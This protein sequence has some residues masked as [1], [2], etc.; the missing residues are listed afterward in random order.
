M[1]LA[2]TLLCRDEIDIVK[3]MLD[4]HF[5]SGVDVI[6]ASDNGSVDG[7]LE[8]LEEY[9]KSDRLILIREPNFIHDQSNWVTRM[10]K[11]AHSEC[12][13]D[14]II[15]SDADEFWCSSSGT[16]KADFASLPDAVSAINVDRT[17]FLPCPAKV[18][19]GVPFHQRMIIRERTSTNSLGMPLPGKVCHRAMEDVLVAAGNHSV[20]F[21]GAKVDTFTSPGIEILHF[22]VRSY[23]QYERKIRQGSQALLSNSKRLDEG[24][25]WIYVYEEFYLKGC[26]TDYYESLVS[27]EEEVR[28][29][30]DAGDLIVDERLATFFR[31]FQTLGLF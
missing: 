17:N 12:R 5:A 1:K 29:R 8:I 27:S 30:M 6:V 28:R 26:L 23:E 21:S 11:I 16:L 9:A 10:A 4:Y 14:W 25:T 15:N 18:D 22:P 19:R 7:T 31:N 2:L 24:A 13:A 3:A 20:S